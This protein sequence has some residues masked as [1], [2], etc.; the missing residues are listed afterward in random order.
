MLDA[1]SVGGLVRATARVSFAFF[2]VGF[3]ATAAHRAWSQRATEWLAG[4]EATALRAL[5]VAHLIHYGCVLWLGALTDF[6][7]LRGPGQGI[8]VAPIVLGVLALGI[9]TGLAVATLPGAAGGRMRRL[10][11]RAW[12]LGVLWLIFAGAYVPRAAGEWFYLPFAAALLG[13][14]TLRLGW[15]ERP[16]AAAAAKG[17]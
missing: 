6:A 5:P 17:R 4:Q 16:L 1:E 11:I 3:A 7:N 2:L 15:R 8:E 10:R 12:G 13:A 9:M 14:L